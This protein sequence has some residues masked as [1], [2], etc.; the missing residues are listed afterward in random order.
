MNV[1][2]GDFDSICPF[3]G[4]RYTIHNLLLI[5]P[6]PWHQLKPLVSEDSNPALVAIAVKYHN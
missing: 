1:F 3:T 4:T 6:A 2:S 5:I